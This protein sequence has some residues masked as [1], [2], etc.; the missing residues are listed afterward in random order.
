MNGWKSGIVAAAFA[1]ALIG[2][3][4][5]GS[6]ATG[7][8]GTSGTA[9]TPTEKMLKIGLVFDSGGRG[10]KSF[11]DSAYRG[12][13]RAIKELGIDAKT[14]DSARES[15]YATN[16][17]TLA[18]SG[19]DLI[20]AIG[21][22]MQKAMSE[23]APK[24]L[25]VKFAIVDAPVDSPNVRSLVFKEEEGSFLAGYVAG[26]MTK[27]GKIGFVGGQEID[28]IKKFQ[29]GYEAGARTAN[30]AIVVLPAKYT[31]DWNNVDLGKQ[32]AKTLY[33]QGADVVYHAAGKCGLGVINAAQEEGKYAIGVDSDQ[34]YLAEGRVLTSMIKRV[35]ESVFQTIN[36]LK[37]GRWD[38]GVKV[39]D[40][41][42]NGVG[43][44]EM[45]FTKDA[46]GE[47]NLAKIKEVQDKIIAGEIKVPAT[48]DE[49][50]TYRVR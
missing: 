23:V 38:T 36:D 33:G 46:I 12:L 28:L 15:D 35:D 14:V 37:E 49:L 25:N 32:N 47:A 40:L 44:S 26:L 34:D 2:C 4:D 3:G 48:M 18:E 10:D 1:F 5:S 43:L 11:N 16:L 22:N 45:Q 24:H 41:K 21:I 8:N 29:A 31:G 30:P 13:E 6:K 39:Y 20:F 17:E 7:D 19:C 27:T 42:S 9:G 50:A